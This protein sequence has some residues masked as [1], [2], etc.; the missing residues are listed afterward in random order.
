M[1]ATRLVL[2]PPDLVAWVND[3][4]KQQLVVTAD[5]RIPTPREECGCLSK[6]GRPQKRPSRA[7]DLFDH[8]YTTR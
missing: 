7:Q 5:N 4:S 8:N 6:L 3:G 1:H 2:L